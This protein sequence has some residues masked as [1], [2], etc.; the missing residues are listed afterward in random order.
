MTKKDTRKKVLNPKTG[1]KVLA[2]GSIGRSMKKKPSSKAIRIVSTAK[3]SAKKIVSNAKQSARKVI[4]NA[5]K[6]ARKAV[7]NAKKSLPK[8]KKR[9]KNKKPVSKPSRKMLQSRNL[10]KHLNRIE[11]KK[12]TWKVTPKGDVRLSA[13]QAFRDGA[14]LGTPHCYGGRC[15]V[16]KSDINGRKYWG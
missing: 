10:A 14:V 3:K 7:L 12:A 6:S 4:S 16:L 2:T 13:A 15:K 9:V 1:R 11:G 5:K 8:T